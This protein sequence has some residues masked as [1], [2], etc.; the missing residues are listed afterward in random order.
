MEVNLSGSEAKLSEL[1][2]V[3]KTLSHQVKSYIPKD[4]FGGATNG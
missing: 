2:N 1:R 3:A 4:V